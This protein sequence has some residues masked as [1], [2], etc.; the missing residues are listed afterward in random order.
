MEVP[1]YSCAGEEE[2]VVF[3]DVPITFTFE[4]MEKLCKSSESDFPALS[5]SFS[6]T[7]SSG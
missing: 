6:E 3:G 7:E 4:V 1:V 5:A 2:R